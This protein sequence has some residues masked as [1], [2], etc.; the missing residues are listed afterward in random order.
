[1]V[2]YARPGNTTH[3]HIVDTNVNTSL[4]HELAS[5]IQ[6]GRERQEYPTTCDTTDRARTQGPCYGTPSLS[7]WTTYTFRAVGLSSG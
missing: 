7:T 2:E 5:V 4:Q 3:H 6:H 1:M